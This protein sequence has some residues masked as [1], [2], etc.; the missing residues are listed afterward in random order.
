MEMPCEHIP[1]AQLILQSAMGRVHVP[2][3][4]R[5]CLV[6]LGLASLFSCWIYRDAILTS[7]ESAKQRSEQLFRELSTKAL[8]KY[9]EDREADAKSETKNETIVEQLP[10]PEVSSSPLDFRDQFFVHVLEAFREPGGREGRRKRFKNGDTPKVV[11]YIDKQF[12][13]SKWYAAHMRDIQEGH[14]PLPCK[15]TPYLSEVKTAD[16]LLIHV[17]SIPSRQKLLQ[18]LHPRDPSQPWIMFEAETHFIATTKYHVDYKTLNGVFNRTMYYRRDADV[19]FNHG[20]VVRRGEDASL[21]PQHWVREP[22][23]ERAKDAPGRLAVAFISNCKS[24]SNRLVYVSEMQKYIA[25]DV[26][27]KCGTL[28]CGKSRYA[29]HEYRVD[30][31]PCLQ[32]AAK[33]YLF[34]LAF[35]NAICDDYATEKLYNMMFYPLVPVVLGGADYDALLPPNSYIDATQYTPLELAKKLQHLADHPQEYQTYLEWRRDYQPSTIGGSRML[36]DLCTR[37]YDQAFYEE[38]TIQDFYDWFV[39]RSHCTAWGAG[40]GTGESLVT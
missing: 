26:Y 19:L 24:H 38:K 12:L 23:V 3:F 39:T 7:G 5:A 37:L 25:V 2:R 14:C 6:F 28:K 32:A 16:A 1:I 30:Q 4:F 11:A 40:N 15:I 35:E 34:Y 22:Q 27:G 17:K 36:C 21:L 18:D 13:K 29:E 31:D 20:F 9:L 10:Y 33:R 8:I